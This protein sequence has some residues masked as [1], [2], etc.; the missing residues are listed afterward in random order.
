MSRSNN[1]LSPTRVRK[2]QWCIVIF[3]VGHSCYSFALESGIYQLSNGVP[4]EIIADPLDRANLKSLRNDNSL[5]QLTLERD[6]GFS[7]QNEAAALVIEDRVIRCGYHGGNDSSLTKLYAGIHG[8]DVDLV[9]ALFRITP[10][11]RVHPG[12][13]LTAK[14]VPDKE[15]FAPGERVTRP[16]CYFKRGPGRFYFC[17]RRT[18]PWRP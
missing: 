18:K 3:L 14:F 11:N 10:Q 8:E 5:Y 4:T 2:A 16:T 6:D 15:S 12:H 9:A 17:A 7:I 13:Q 1:V